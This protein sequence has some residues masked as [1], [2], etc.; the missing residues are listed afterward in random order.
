MKL[1][2]E[3]GLKD[4]ESTLSELMACGKEALEPLRKYLLSGQ[5]RGV[6]QGRQW[7]VLALARLGAKNTLL[8]YLNMLKNI[9]D[10]VVQFGEEAVESTALRELARW[11]TEATFLFLVDFTRK[12]KRIGAFESL[13]EFK[14]REAV[15]LLIDAL[16]DGYYG[17]AAKRAVKKLGRIAYQE[18]L[19]TAASIP[20]AR[21]SPSVTHRN[22]TVITLLANLGVAEK[23]WQFLRGLLKNHDAGIV[24]RTAQIAAKAAPK[25]DKTTAARLA[26][27]TY[28]SADWRT[29]M[30][31]GLEDLLLK[32]QPES[33][34]VIVKE[35]KQNKYSEKMMERLMLIKS[36]LN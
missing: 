26:I 29:Q 31:I 12:N 24:I 34:A 18:L 28:P 21:T 20:V 33:K 8:E 25:A 32:L 13:G 27:A 4:I 6:Y 19:Q 2:A 36:K 30:E 11:P 5:P 14:R 35:I 22:R 3:I 15:P 17:S 16:G 1:I 9:S 7:A 23:D 10:P